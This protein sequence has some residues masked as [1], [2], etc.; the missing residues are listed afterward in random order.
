[1]VV[2]EV[3]TDERRSEVPLSSPGA[4]PSSYVS[5][6][7]LQAVNEELFADEL[8]VINVAGGKVGDVWDRRMSGGMNC[9]SSGVA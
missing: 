4:L 7:D 9:G 8:R 6:V 1:M 3:E 2:C 5:A